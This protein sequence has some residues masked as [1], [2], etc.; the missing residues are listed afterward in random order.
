MNSLMALP[1][2]S[3]VNRLIGCGII[4]S[5]T[6]ITS[7][8]STC[9]FPVVTSDQLISRYRAFTQ[10]GST[11]SSQFRKEILKRGATAASLDLLLG[12]HATCLPVGDDIQSRPTIGS[13]ICLVVFDTEA[14]DLTVIFNVAG[15]DNVYIMN[16]IRDKKLNIL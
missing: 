16:S 8:C 13:T 12:P 5:A 4:V 11:N 7:G 15:C 3:I 10:S 9:A 14:E 2:S 6:F 1:S